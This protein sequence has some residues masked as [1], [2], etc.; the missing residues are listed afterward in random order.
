MLSDLN[1]LA[2]EAAD[3]ALARWDTLPTEERL[4]VMN[5]ED[6]RVAGAVAQEIPHIARAVDAAA[7]SLSNG[8]RLIYVGAGTSGRLG[9]LDA[10]EC[11]PTFGVAPDRV[12]A[13]IAGGPDAVFRAIE[14]AEDDAQAGRAAVAERGITAADTVVGLSASGR[15][16][17]V[18]GALREARARGAYTVSVACCRPSEMGAIVHVEIAPLVG[19]EVLAG[20]TRL[21]SGTAQKL[22]LNMISTGAMAAWGK[23]YGNLMVDVQATNAKLKVRARRLV[24]TVAGVDT[25]TADAALM[26]AEGN[27]KVAIVMLKRGVDAGGARQL[28]TDAGGFLRRVLEG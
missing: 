16:P 7:A 9:V 21:K 2:T 5:A 25:P 3:P 12:Q 6:A 24:C 20:S 13:I 27:A 18:I 11:P 23:T 10:S 15:A 14:G 22:V 1:S 17:F 19:P 28:L 4:R 26:D 8:G